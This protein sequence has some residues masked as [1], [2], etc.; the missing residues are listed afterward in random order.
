MSRIATAVS[1][2]AALFSLLLSPAAPAADAQRGRALYES[3]CD[4]CHNTG[5][6]QRDSRKA[7]SYAA[8]RE[9][10]VRWN[11][12]LNGA[13]TNEEIEDVTLFLNDRY[14]NFDC[15]E[16]VCGFKRSQAPAAGALAATRA[17]TER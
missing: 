16:A 15:P 17:P 5:V 7:Q 9:E 3:R 11:R 12:T 14:Y 10:V 2:V 1:I 13:W 4:V 8:I 6:H